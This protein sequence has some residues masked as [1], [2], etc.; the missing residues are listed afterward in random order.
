MLNTAGGRKTMRGASVKITKLNELLLAGYAE[1]QAQLSACLEE[2]AQAPSGSLVT[3]RR[4]VPLKSGRIAEYVFHY[5]QNT[6]YEN[7][8]RWDIQHY[9]PRKEE[10]EILAVYARRH[11]NRTRIRELL[12]ELKLYQRL[13]AR[14]GIKLDSEEI[15]QNTRLA[16]HIET[17]RKRQLAGHLHNQE[18][19][20][21]TS[22][23]N[24]VRSRIEGIT[25]GTLER[26]AIA[27]S[28]E[29][30]APV[31]K[32]DSYGR[33]SVYHPDFTLY[34][35]QQKIYLEVLGKMDTSK[36]RQDWAER[37]EVYRRSG[38]ILGKNLAAVACES[39]QDVDIRKIDEVVVNMKEGI[40]PDKIIN[41][42]LSDI[43]TKKA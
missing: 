43:R 42:G 6:F 13:L 24:I 3:K 9:I 30:P 18:Y 11:A 31:D 21:I 17:C 15:L 20:V 1:T 38:I 23:G 40:I 37:Q 22:Q 19:H 26:H 32:Y 25:A 36:Y 7:G 8:R 5:I 34:I 4:K 28:Y 27:Y 10:A 2:N 29:E 39:M 14:Q 41:I 33:P 35:N 12:H 16:R